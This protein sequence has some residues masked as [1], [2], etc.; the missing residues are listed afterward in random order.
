MTTNGLRAAIYLQVSRDD[1]TTE[2]QRR[3]LAW[4]AE[5]R[6]WTIVQ[7]YEDQGIS[8]AKAGIS[9]PHSTKC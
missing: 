4:V 6:D 2:N 9:V 1:Q 8:G 7:T 3:V 5:H